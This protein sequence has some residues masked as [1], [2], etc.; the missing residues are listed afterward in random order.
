MKA[1]LF[2]L[3]ANLLASAMFLY[4]EK[5]GFALFEKLMEIFSQIKLLNHYEILRKQQQQQLTA[6]S[7]KCKKL[8]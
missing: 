6:R 1:T 5:D 8:L 4:I 7:A 2:Y 3:N